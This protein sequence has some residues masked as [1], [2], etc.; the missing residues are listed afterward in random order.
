MCVRLTKIDQDKEAETIIDTAIEW[1]SKC[2]PFP[3]DYVMKFLLPLEPPATY[4]SKSPPDLND[5]VEVGTYRRLKVFD[6]SVHHEGIEGLWVNYKQ[7][8]YFACDFGYY[9]MDMR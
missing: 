3:D 6:P 4:V 2:G 8:N 9:R 1:R 5:A 7:E